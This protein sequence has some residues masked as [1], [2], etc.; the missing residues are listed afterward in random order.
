M[1]LKNSSEPRLGDPVIDPTN[2]RGEKRSREE[3]LE[4]ID[5]LTKESELEGELSESS[6]KPFESIE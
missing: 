4:L 3:I 2:I 6:K 5:D 1:T